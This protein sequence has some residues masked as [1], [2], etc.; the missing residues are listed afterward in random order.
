MPETPSCPGDGGGVGG[1]QMP[2][3]LPEVADDG[4]QRGETVAA[5]ANAAPA[6]EVDRQN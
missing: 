4:G 6:E 2:A 1:R 5:E 3:Q